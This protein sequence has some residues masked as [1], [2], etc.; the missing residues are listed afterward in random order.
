MRFAIGSSLG[1]SA[2]LALKSKNLNSIH[3]TRVRLL[4]P[5]AEHWW[6]LEVFWVYRQCKFLHDF[7]I[8]DCRG[9]PLMNEEVIVFCT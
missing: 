6:I 4:T 8:Q 7:M 1:L 2:L 9:K 3:L 5:N